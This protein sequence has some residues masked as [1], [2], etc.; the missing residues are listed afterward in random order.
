MNNF[1]ISKISWQTMG[2][3]N[4]SI[5]YYQPTID[6]LSTVLEHG[7]FTLSIMQII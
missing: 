4:S 6:T 2:K 3:L 5:F 7:W 1:F